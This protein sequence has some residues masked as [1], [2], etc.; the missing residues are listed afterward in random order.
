[1]SDHDDPR[2]EGTAGG[3]GGENGGTGGPADPGD[4]STTPVGA[5]DG[6][7]ESESIRLAETGVGSVDRLLAAD[8]ADLAAR[9]GFPESTVREWQSAADA[10]QGGRGDDDVTG[11]DPGSGSADAGEGHGT[12]ETKLYS[13]DPEEAPGPPDADEVPSDPAAGSGDDSN[14]TFADDPGAGSGEGSTGGSAGESNVRSAGDVTDRTDPGGS[15]SRGGEVEPERTEEELER[16]ILPPE[17]RV[18][19][20]EAFCQSCGEIVDED[21]AI[22]PECG[23]RQ[24][25]GEARSARGSAGEV[26][27]KTDE[28]VDAELAALA[29]L[30]V[31]GAGALLSG[32]TTRA[33]GWFAALL[34]VLFLDLV[35]FVVSFVLTAIVVGIFGF[36]LIPIVHLVF[37]PIAAY[38]AYTQAKKINAGEVRVD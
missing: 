32:Q 24:P 21:A 28:E 10:G 16:E 15:V 3:T 2:D 7:G 9:T 17:E 12:D 11:S 38:D 37:H 13:G 19:P 29:S 34:G 1:M 36:L 5:V 18:G 14:F 4:G 22:C 30:F 31:P 33:T 35:I 6:I 27:S 20:G 26:A 8:P 25:G 23:V